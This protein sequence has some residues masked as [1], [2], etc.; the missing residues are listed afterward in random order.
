MLVLALSLGATEG[1]E[2]AAQPDEAAS[3][4]G[5]AIATHDDDDDT[6]PSPTDA[7]APLPPPPEAPASDEGFGWAKALL[8]GQAVAEP[9]EPP[10]PPAP[11]TLPPGEAPLVVVKTLL[12][13]LALIVLA[14]LGGHSR[15]RALEEK[16]GISRVVAAGFPFLLL[17]FIAASDPVG[18]LS[19]SVIAHLR[20]ILHLALGWLGLLVGLRVEL[21]RLA[22]LPRGTPMILAVGT[23]LPFL[24][25]AVGCGVLLVLTHA[26][27]GE[28]LFDAELLRDA[29][30]LG[31]AGAMAADTDAI[32]V[33]MR[34]ATD[35]ARE[36]VGL[37]ASLDETVGLIGLVFL[38]AYFRPESTWQL[39]STAW[40]FIGVGLPACVG[41][42][43]YLIVRLRSSSHE[44]V[45]LL[46]GSVAFAAG[47]AST[48]RLSA[49]AVCFVIGVLLANFPGE[50]QARLREMLGRLEAPIYLLFLLVAGARWQPQ[51]VLG[52]ALV[53]VLLG[54]RL[55]GRFIGA[56]VA[57]RRAD[58]DL[59][60]E[61]R[62]ALALSP[63]GILP[64][65]IAVNAELLH[66]NDPTLPAITSAVIAAT[67]L[68]EFFAQ[69]YWR[70][71]D[72]QAQLQPET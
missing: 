25:I 69:L 8:S 72:R 6:G 11:E 50:Y 64:I 38:T 52:W 42:V 5:G 17:G 58:V 10:P 54:A 51:A 7:A 35:V 2:A 59:P 41:F 27:A 23:G 65:A 60:R 68:L 66:P 21:G 46:L 63:L 31:A 16:L 15:V 70:S 71:P 26:A 49:L 48:L 9:S 61:A 39:P 62:T 1:P 22:T 43:V 32:R 20:P 40:L 14:Y 29:L 28:P 12:G 33:A 56:R 24:L 36:R 19:P 57:W 30:V 3:S 13:L 47:V 55:P 37:I 45:A 4:T 34:R 44:M 67:I 18:I 53:I